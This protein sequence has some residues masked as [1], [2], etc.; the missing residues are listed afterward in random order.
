[1]TIA[2]RTHHRR[3]AREAAVLHASIRF[4]RRATPALLPV[5]ACVPPHTACRV[6]PVAVPATLE[7]LGRKRGGEQQWAR[8]EAPE[9]LAATRTI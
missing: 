8:L 9:V 6:K 4:T 5:L 7:A 3:P 2:G 1:M